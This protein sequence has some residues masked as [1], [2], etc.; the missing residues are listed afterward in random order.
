MKRANKSPLAPEAFAALKQVRENLRDAAL[1]RA[2]KP[3][4]KPKPRP[5]SVD[6]AQLFRR[7]VADV[8]P[9]PPGNRADLKLRKPKP[10]ALKHE[11][12][13]H[14]ALLDSLADPWDHEDAL[15]TGDEL[16]YYRPGVPLAALRK[17]R[18]GGWVVRA[19]L[20]LHGM[21]SDEARLAT[22]EFL[23][24]CGRQERRYVRIIHGKGLGSKQK[25]PVLK[26]K[27][28]HW[29]IQREDVLAFCQARAVD[30]GAGAVYVMLKSPD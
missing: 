7:A 30:G 26:N 13:E 6:D 25:L 10:R 21:T 18:R 3:P 22:A 12:D 16:L 27:L 15:A 11:A 8:T 19:E 1:T 20:D 23:N 9:L 17:M 14:Q 29:L 4:P 5:K 28:R 2:A 24:R